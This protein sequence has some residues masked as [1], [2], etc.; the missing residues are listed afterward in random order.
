MCT[1]N[2]I[3][4]YGADPLIMQWTVVRGD[5]SPLSIHFLEDDE[6]T[7]VDTS[8]WTVK[9][10]SYDSSVDLL[11]DLN[12][13]VSDGIVNI[14]VPASIT[15]NWGLGYKNIVS[16]LQ[17]DLQVTITTDDNSV[18]WTPVIGTIRVLGDITPGG[19][20]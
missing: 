10:T 20:L 9:A 2:K 16:E 13:T 14:S 5:T 3:G 7:F 18:V 6:T 19:S 8:T 11:D 4:Q 1:T 12:A 15:E 17:F